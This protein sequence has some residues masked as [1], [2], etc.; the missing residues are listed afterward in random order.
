[1]D[2]RKLPAASGGSSV[3]KRRKKKGGLECRQISGFWWIYGTLRLKDR[4][5]RLRKS[6]GIPADRPQHEAEAARAKIEGQY[7]EESVFGVKPSATFATVTLAWLNTVQPGATDILMSKKLVRKFGANLV[8]DLVA[9]DIAGFVGSMANR[10]PATINRYLNV[11]H[12]ILALGVRLGYA[13]AVPHFERPRVKKVAVN[14]MLSMAELDLL[15]AGAAP[16]VAGILALMAVTGCRVSEAVYLQISD[17]ILAPGRERVIFR[18]TKNSETYGASLHPFAVPHIVK[19]I[20]RH[21]EGPVFL[22]HRRR[23]YELKEDGGGQIK[24]AFRTARASL[25]SALTEA[26]QLERAAIVAK[27]TPHWL[28]HSFASHLM[29]QGESV[30]TIMDAG[31]WKTARLVMETYSHLAPDA[32]REAVNSLPFG[33]NKADATQEEG[34]KKA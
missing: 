16:H 18:D 21:Q 11:L 10:K 9:A 13:D 26:G 29:A 14:K 25:V 6:L 20:G 7:I 5:V 30:K 8:R 23:P 17:V 28:R 32:T 31:R 27:A 15:F 19:A 34:K 3:L 1:M 2:G 33:S 12:A 4:S 24:T 22:T